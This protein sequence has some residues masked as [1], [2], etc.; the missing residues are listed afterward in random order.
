MLNSLA[1]AKS[2]YGPPMRLLNAQVAQPFPRWR[3][4][5]AKLKPEGRL[6]LYKFGRK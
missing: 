2:G 4:R 3:Q 1:P 5:T 6:S